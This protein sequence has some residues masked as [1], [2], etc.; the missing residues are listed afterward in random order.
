MDLPIREL[1]PAIDAPAPSLGD[2]IIRNMEV[3]LRDWED[4]SYSL[5]PATLSNRQT[6]RGHARELLAA[7]AADLHSPPSPQ[8]GEDRLPARS[9]G[10]SAALRTA[11]EQ[12]AL[13]RVAEHV[14]LEQII[15]EFSAVRRLVLRRWSGRQAGGLDRPEELLRFNEALDGALAAAVRHFA[16]THDSIIN[17]SSDAIVGR[18]TAGIITSWNPGAARIFGYTAQEA[19]GQSTQMLFPPGQMSEELDILARIARGDTVQSYDTTRL[20][21]DGEL[22]HV[23]VTV[24]PITDGRGFIVGASKI[25][26]DISRRKKAEA[27]LLASEE[28]F[29]ALANSIPQLAW[30]AR[31]DGYIFWY[32]QRWYDFT[33]TTPDQVLGWGWQGVLDQQVLPRIEAQWRAAVAAGELFEME[34]PLR[35]ADGSFREFLNRALPIK[36]PAGHVVQWAGTNTDVHELKLAEAALR[37]NQSLLG[38]INE[39]L[40][41]AAGENR[42]IAEALYGEKERAQVTLNS[43][44]DAVIC[45]TLDG[46]LSYL[47]GAAERLTQWSSAEATGRRLEEVFHI[48]DAHSR[49]VIDNI[50]AVAVQRNVVSKLPNWCILV[51]P[52]GSELP[53]EET[54][55]PIHTRDGKVAG[56]VMVFQDV[57][58][59]RALSQKLAHQAAHDGLTG[60]PNRTQL[61]DR[62]AHAVALA[63]RHHR[64]LALLYLDVDC[65]K[66]INDSLG[67][68]IGDELL[69]TVAARLTATVR[70]SDT[71]SRLGGDEFVVVVTDFATVREVA[72]CAEKILQAL[73]LPYLLDPHVLHVSASIGV[74][75][76]PQDGIEPE[77]LL[78]NADSAMYAAKKRGRD[79]YRFYGD[80]MNEDGLS[81]P[82][83]RAAPAADRA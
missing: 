78:R 69:R 70:T 27:D 47:N 68:S 17:S 83:P 2:F 55:A 51:R 81:R 72:V 64:P 37:S 60:L 48:V 39:D 45:T 29:R 59:A 57:S 43:I 16:H 30:T 4:Y 76:C 14:D 77:A 71:V 13:A 32:N 73:R 74:A 25:A 7:L 75:I 58:A 11:G 22:V 1:N 15:G 53:I 67:H 82:A 6:L 44:G 61:N 10:P 66:T 41:T 56:A 34:F 18:T 24:S 21:K 46:R 79:N 80:A 3:L 19:I 49:E 26:R 33:G 65:F 42:R 54:C 31:A 12:H 28:R 38:R 52:D 9:S 23:S 36:D 63:N 40:Q 8:I 62:L 20:R 50:M 5:F 35:A